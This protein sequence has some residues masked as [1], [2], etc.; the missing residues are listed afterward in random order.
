MINKNIIQTIKDKEMDRKTFL[1]YGGLLFLSL[2]GVKTVFAFINQI[3]NKA[4]TIETPK[5][6]TH[7]FGASKYGT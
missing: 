5:K 1:K 6:A 2:V 3:D 7:G 4:I